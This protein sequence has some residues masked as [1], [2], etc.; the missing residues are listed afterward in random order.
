VKQ[1]LND[2]VFMSTAMRAE[3]YCELSMCA[4]TDDVNDR[5]GSRLHHHYV[6]CT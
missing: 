4:R 6:K 1:Q 5:Y 2:V 3:L